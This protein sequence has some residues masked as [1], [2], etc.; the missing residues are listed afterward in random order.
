MKKKEKVGIAIVIILAIIVAVATIAIA[1]NGIVKYMEGSEKDNNFDK[2]LENLNKDGGSSKVLEVNE[3]L[4]AN[5]KVEKF[6]GNS[7]LLMLRG[8]IDA[9]N[10]LL[11][12]LSNNKVAKLVFNPIIYD[13]ESKEE[14]VLDDISFY[15]NHTISP[16]GNYIVYE[17]SRLW[18]EGGQEIKYVN[19]ENFEVKSLKFQDK[20]NV[21]NSFWL[22]DN[23]FYMGL[24]N[25]TICEVNLSN[26]SITPRII[27]NDKNIK[28]VGY[29][30]DNLYYYCHEYVTGKEAY[31][32][33]TLKY[34]N[35]KTLKSTTLYQGRPDNVPRYYFF[36]NGY[37]S[38]EQLKNSDGEKVKVHDF[39]GKILKQTTLKKL[40]NYSTEMK[41]SKDG[42]YVFY[43]ISLDS[44]YSEV[45]AF[46]IETGEVYSLVKASQII[47]IEYNNER[48]I[49]NARD[50]YAPE[51]YSYIIDDFNK[52][53]PEF[54]ESQSDNIKKANKAEEYI[55]KA[56][57]NNGPNS[58]YS[59]EMINGKVYYEI[60]VNTRQEY[61]YTYY[62][63]EE[64]NS[65]IREWDELSFE[66][67]DSTI[68]PRVNYII[69]YGYY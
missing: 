58:I 53:E 28:I 48:L 60:C 56:L 52:K 11:D 32:D 6:L 47:D 61:P 5:G 44:D 27:E 50:K 30:N 39:N 41:V 57:N 43:G 13:R 42:R 38:L 54:L 10:P 31:N 8:E 7:K 4:I 18:E 68:L 22:D 40:I 59:A 1:V 17:K 14:R 36:D 33:L 51:V 46:D 67:Y 29:V 55:N 35:L 63:N 49:V 2:I 66:S 26:G 21:V 9:K 69:Q 15:D 23:R 16:N 37:I 65:Y 64:S 62:V 12:K 24:P 20:V 34:L 3:N 25:G 45:Q 19:T